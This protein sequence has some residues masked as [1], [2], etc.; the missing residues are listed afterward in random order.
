MPCP[1][2]PR[3]PAVPSPGTA[4]SS[5]PR[6]CGRHTGARS[7][8]PRRTVRAG[9]SRR[10]PRGPRCRRPSPSPRRSASS[11]APSEHQGGTL[12]GPAGCHFPA[13]VALAAWRRAERIVLLGP[14]V[15]DE[16]I[17]RA[18][19]RHR[20]DVG[21]VLRGRPEQDP[22]HR[23]LHLLAGESG[24]YLAHL[25]DLVRYVAR[26]VLLAQPITYL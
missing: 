20:V 16:L 17:Q 22:A 18:R 10:R 13:L 26:R 25:D 2:R 14:G 12:P 23:Y 4:G 5:C 15:T 7:P 1:T 11:P 19:I 8:A 6:R 21:R 3:R 24:R 9:P